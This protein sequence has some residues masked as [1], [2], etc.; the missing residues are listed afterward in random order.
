VNGFLQENNFCGV[1]KYRV[2]DPCVFLLPAKYLG[3]HGK[4]YEMGVVCG[5][6]GIEEKDIRSSGWKTLRKETVSNT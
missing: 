2:E 4:K 6:C 5:V 3:E 1:F